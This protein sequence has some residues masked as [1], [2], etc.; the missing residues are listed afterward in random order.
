[1]CVVEIR[2]V[3]SDTD[4]S[5]TGAPDPVTGQVNIR[6]TGLP[7]SSVTNTNWSLGSSVEGNAGGS[8]VIQHTEREA[9]D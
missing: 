9:L 1:M 7:F 5:M 2:E 8:P 4:H 6:D 3:L